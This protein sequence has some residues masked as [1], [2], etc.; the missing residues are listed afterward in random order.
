MIA[1]LD[2]PVWAALS[3]KQSHFNIGNDRV[4]YFP[5]NVSPFIGLKDWNESD[6]EELIHHAPS[7]RSFSVMIAKEVGL[8]TSFDI[9]FT[10]PLY[11]MICPVLKPFTNPDIAF[12][13]LENKDVAQMLA[14]TEMTRPG[15]F[16]EKTIDFGKYTGVFNGDELIS[17]AGERLKVNGYTEVSAICTQ[18][19]Y[20]GKGYAS[21]LLSNVSEGIMQEGGIPFL[22]VRTD[23][24]RAIEV[25]KKLGFKIRTEVY[26]AVF[27]KSNLK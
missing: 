9:L 5:S 24:I 1:S 21:C 3:S 20:L 4:K 15:P 25:Y 6:L 16:Y 14:L 18:P 8:S 2:N 12:R 17:M 10:T 26:F 19:A 27:K 23:N 11:Q 13:S 7:E 22:H